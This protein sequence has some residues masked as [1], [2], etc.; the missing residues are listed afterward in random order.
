M[1]GSDHGDFVQLDS[2]VLD[3]HAHNGHVTFPRGH[4]QRQPA[5]LSRES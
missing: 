1:T 2:G 4:G 5:A 3:E